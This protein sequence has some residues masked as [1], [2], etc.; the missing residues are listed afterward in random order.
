MRKTKSF[1]SKC[2]YRK[3]NEDISHIISILDVNDKRSYVENFVSPI[4]K[5]PSYGFNGRLKWPFWIIPCDNVII[6]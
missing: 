6:L 4:Q 5:V 2:V 3:L 1:G